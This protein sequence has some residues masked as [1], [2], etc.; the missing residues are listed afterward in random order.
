MYDFIKKRM[1]LYSI[2]NVIFYI[3]VEMEYIPIFSDVISNFM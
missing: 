3:K 1:G 2:W